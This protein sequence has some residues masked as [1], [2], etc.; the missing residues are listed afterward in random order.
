MDKIAPIFQS[1]RVSFA[2]DA[3]GKQPIGVASPAPAPVDARP[4]PASTHSVSSIVDAII[5]QG[6][7]IDLEKIARVKAEI[8]RG[9]YQIDP[10]RIADA[11]LNPSARNK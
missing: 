6:P 7:P 4:K 9:S 2:A 10:D 1:G 3:T 8:A 11:L 5:A